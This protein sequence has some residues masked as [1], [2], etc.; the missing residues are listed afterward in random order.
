MSD[1][2]RD[3]TVQR[4]PRYT[5]IF[6]LS[7]MF[8]RGSKDEKLGGGPLIFSASFLYAV[9][10]IPRVV[11][12]DDSSDKGLVG[13]VH[14]KLSSYRTYIFILSIYL[15]N[16]QSALSVVIALLPDQSDQQKMMF[17]DVR[18]MIL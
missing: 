18:A 14:V 17:H 16:V 13:S 2:S 4:N 12:V 8:G 3:E 11:D 6:V 7:N 1:G 5:V 9:E 15:T 10:S